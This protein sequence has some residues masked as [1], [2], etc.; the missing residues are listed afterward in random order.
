MVTSDQKLDAGRRR[1]PQPRARRHRPH[2]QR[3][4]QRLNLDQ[5]QLGLEDLEQSVAENQAG[6]EAAEAQQGRRLAP[7][8]RNHGA[9]PEHLPR[10]EVLV[11]VERRD[12]PCCGGTLHAI[13]EL[14]T[15]QLDIVPAQLR[16]RVTRRPRYACRACEGAVVVAPAPERLID[17]GM[18]TEALIVHVLVSKFCDSLPLYRQG[19]MLARQGIT[20]DRSTLGSDVYVRRVGR[21]CWWLTPL[22]DLLVGTALSA[23]KLFADDTTLPV[24]DPGRGR[25]KTGRLWCYAVDDR[26]W[27]G[28]GHPVAAYV[29][30]EDR[31]GI[32][33][34]AHLAAFRGVLQ[35]DGYP[36]FKRLAGDRADASVGLAFCWAHMRRH[37]YEFHAY[38][39]SP[40]AAEV[41]AQ[42][43]ALYAIEGLI[44]GH[45]AEHRRQA[46]QERSRPVVEALHAWLQV[47]QDRVSAASDLAKAIRCALRHWPGLTVFLN[48]GRVEMDSNVVERAIRPVALGRK[49]ALFAGSDGGARQWA[50]AMT[51]IQT[52]KLNGVD[53]QAWLT[54][55]LERIVSGRTKATELDTLLPWNW[56]SNNSAAVPAVAA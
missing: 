20:L 27:C 9:L 49:N 53:P 4:C 34:A 38:T 39:Q 33:P 19:Q 11:D 40:L 25:T 54:D 12:C 29:Y 30:T 43:R 10:Y 24:L 14:R 45:P 37:F 51:L 26:P 17:G 32:R 6:Q 52:A 7:P 31:K 46:R 15:E 44:R 18:A 28:P 48:D 35:V 42:V 47:H 3:R 50:I 1:L 36:G 41:L 22:Y 5:L 56:K 13:G 55:V 21:A 16:V 2:S 23:P 8:R